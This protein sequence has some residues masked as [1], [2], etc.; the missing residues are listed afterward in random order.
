MP[1]LVFDDS[2]PANQEKYFPLLEQTR[3]HNDLYCVG[4]REK[5]QFLGYLNARLRDARSKGSSGG[6]SFDILAAFKDMLGK[7]VSEIPENDAG[8]VA[9]RYRDGSGDECTKDSRSRT[10]RWGSVPEVL[11]DGV[12]GCIVDSVDETRR[13]FQ[14]RFDAPRMAEDYLDVY[15]GLVPG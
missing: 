5:E 4:P 14:E 1:I 9:R 6:L 13:V 2:S 12:T 10:R 15:R 11:E 3:T 8:G 7:P